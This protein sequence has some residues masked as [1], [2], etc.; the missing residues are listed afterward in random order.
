MLSNEQVENVKKQLISQLESSDV[1]NKEAIQSSIE[2]MDSEQLEEFLNKNKL[3][4]KDNQE[5]IF[6]SILSQDISSY[7][8]AENSEAIAVLEINPISQGHSI[9]IPKLHSDT[10]SKISFDLAEEVSK[11]ISKI[12]KPKRIDIVNSNLFGHEIINLVPIYKNENIHSKRQQA[13]PEDLEEIQK[14]LEEIQEPIKEKKS[15]EEKPKRQV[16]T[17]KNF[18]LPKRIP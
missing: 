11:K 15:Q 14:Q 3:I 16:F 10:P 7:K 18:W 13:K 17:E 9:I 4:K 12:F 8:I 1:E 6:C 2:A 5:C